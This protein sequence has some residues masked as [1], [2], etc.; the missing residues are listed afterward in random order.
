ME[1]LQELVDYKSLNI[2]KNCKEDIIL[3]ISLWH[4][5]QIIEKQL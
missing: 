1:L 5:Q 2:E 3:F 4:V